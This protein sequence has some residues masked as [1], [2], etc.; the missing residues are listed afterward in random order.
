MS[1]QVRGSGKILFAAIIAFVGGAIFPV[2]LILYIAVSFVASQL[3]H[4]ENIL[5][6]VG[7]ALSVGVL[8]AIFTVIDELNKNIAAIRSER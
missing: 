2:G 8:A 3:F 1:T 6:P 7:A 4:Q 5:I